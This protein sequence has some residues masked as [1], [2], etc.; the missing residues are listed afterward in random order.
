MK[1]LSPLHFCPSLQAHVEISN[2]FDTCIT[3][4]QCF[5]DDPCPLMKQ[6]T[7]HHNAP[8]QQLTTQPTVKPCKNQT[9]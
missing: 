4:H 7:E 1:K 8:K 9:Y 3:Q 2:G 5:S 6:F